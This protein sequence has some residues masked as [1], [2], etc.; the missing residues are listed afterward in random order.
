M[1]WLEWIG[2]AGCFASDYAEKRAIRL[3]TP[4]QM[5]NQGNYVVSL[6]DVTRWLG[7]QAEALGV[8]VY[9]GFAAA[10]FLEENGRVVGV[11][12]GDMGI[13]KEGN[14]G[15]DHAPGMD[16]R[17]TYTLFAEGCR[18]SLSKQAITRFDLRRRADPQTYAIGI[19]ELW[20]IPAAKHKPG[21]IEHTVGWPLDRTTYGGSWLYHFSDNL[22]SYGFVIGLDYSNPWLSPFDEMQRF[23]AH[24]KMRHH[25]E[26]GRRIS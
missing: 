16:L 26:G 13:T 23:K 3:P 25:F 14:P 20:E 8:E 22:V 4:P 6:G 15:A 18:G 24:P 1:H 10:T 11:G 21:L 5:H 19:K 12:T 9:P 7:Q 17:A 2:I